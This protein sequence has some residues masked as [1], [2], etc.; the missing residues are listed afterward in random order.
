MGLYSRLGN[1]AVRVSAH[2]L[3]VPRLVDSS[4][5]LPQLRLLIGIKIIETNV[6][7]GL[8]VT[9]YLRPEEEEEPQA[10]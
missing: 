5:D 1:G 7:A 2:Q 6:G 4:K 3:R 8:L 9:S 10:F